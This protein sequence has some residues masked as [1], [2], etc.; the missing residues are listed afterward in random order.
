MPPHK[1]GL[2][3]WGR[4]AREIRLLLRDPSIT[5]LTT[6][7]DYYG[8]PADVPGMSTRPPGTPHERVAHVERAI[9]EAIGDHRFLPN[10]V[11]HEIEAWVLLG[12]DELGALSGD[13]TLPAAVRKLVADAEGAEL[14]NDGP[15]TA[16]SKR[17]LNLCPRYRK[18]SDGPLVIAEVGID[19]IRRACPH[20]DAWFAALTA[21][22]VGRG[23]G[24]TV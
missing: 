14:V 21:A 19:A 10:L 20:A 18:T 11:L 23:A 16:P 17:L 24:R 4:L 8:L 22:L 2:A 1:G 15:S 12:H 6:L 9:G 7:L 5:T 3:A 13:A